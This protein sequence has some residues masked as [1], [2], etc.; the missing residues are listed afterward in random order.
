MSLSGSR[1]KKGIVVRII[2]LINISGIFMFFLICSIL[3]Y[4]KIL[5]LWHNSKEDYIEA[6]IQPL[7]FTLLQDDAVAFVAQ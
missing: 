1:Q 7:K 6:V 3:L 2:P 5:G 4:F